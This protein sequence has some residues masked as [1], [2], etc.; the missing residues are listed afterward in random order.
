MHRL[1][2]ELCDVTKSTKWGLYS[3][4]YQGGDISIDTTV[5]V[6]NRVKYN[7]LTIIFAPL[8]HIPKRLLN[9]DCVLVQ[10]ILIDLKGL[11]EYWQYPN[12]VSALLFI[13]VLASC[14]NMYSLNM[15]L[16]KIIVSLDLILL[17]LTRCRGGRNPHW[18]QYR[19]GLQL[20]QH[21]THTALLYTTSVVTYHHASL[22]SFIVFQ[23]VQI[24]IKQSCNTGPQDLIAYLCH[25][26]VTKIAA[27]MS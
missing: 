9:T 7:C 23:L 15:W 12:I 21:C 19:G 8:V 16:K 24:L 5:T 22:N 27:V 17:L 25:F 3:T 1:E 26:F 20:T 2:R 13:S 14:N 6:K 11:K 10:W 4:K 18:P